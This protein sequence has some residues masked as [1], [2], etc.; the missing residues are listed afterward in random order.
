MPITSAQLAAGANY[1]LNSYAKNDPVDQFTTAR[2]FAQWLIKNKQESVFGNGI[3]NEKVRISNNSNYQNYTRDDQ[4]TYNTKDT[5]RLAPFQHYEAH[6]GFA[7]N[8]TDMADNGIVLT[9]D[10]NAV[11]TEAE[12]IQ[13]VNRLKENY[14][15]LKD[16][17]QQNWDL[18]IH[19]D[20]TASTKSCPGLDLLVSTT[21]TSATVVGGID[22]SINAY[23]Q[24]NASIGINTGTAG[25][26]VQAMEVQWR[27]CMTYGGMSPDA[28]FVGSA[29]LDAYRKDALSTVNRQIILGSGKNTNI[30]ASTDTSGGT[31]GLYFKGVEL[32]WDP[33]FDVL[34]STTPGWA[35]RCY[36]LQSKHMVLRPNKGRWLINRKPDRVYDRY[37]HYFGLTA[38][39]GLT[40]KKR[41][42]MAVLSIA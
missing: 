33:T 30:D 21:P 1:Q 22:Q 19:K 6:D 25:T 12:Q 7:V 31:S 26:L 20:G 18:E 10:K 2:P 17:F 38:D 27:K 9:D 24:N 32:M 34:D 39:Y 16:G 37:T 5:V 11:L 41:N 35:K 36:F 28:I 42:S 23:W 40:V 13:I 29:F 8:E 4:V 14:A 15:T 3:F